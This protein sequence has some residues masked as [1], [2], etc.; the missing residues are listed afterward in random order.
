MEQIKQLQPIIRYTKIIVGLV[1]FIALISFSVSAESLIAPVDSYKIIFKPQ[2]FATTV[3]LFYFIVNFLL[4]LHDSSRL[5]FGTLTIFLL[6]PS[7]I[8]SCL[9]V[10]VY[11]K[12]RK[13]K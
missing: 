5:L 3:A 11:N 6:I 13:R 12:F 2:V 10:W 4:Y 1:I 9:I 7:Y 8:M